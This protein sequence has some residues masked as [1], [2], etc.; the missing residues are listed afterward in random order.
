[1][2]EYVFNDMYNIAGRV[3]EIDP[4]LTISYDRAKR[5]YH[6]MRNRHRVMT[7]KQLDER[8]LTKLR[9]GDL[10]RRSLEAFIRELEHSEDELERRKA[11]ELSNTVE[12]LSLDYFDRIVGIPHYS[13]GGI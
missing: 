6:V 4:A 1:M 3:K 8:V 11:R 7:V 12:S 2:S 13:L 10:Q 9:W 5:E